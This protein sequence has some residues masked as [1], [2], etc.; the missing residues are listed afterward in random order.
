MLLGVAG[1]KGG[2]E[3]IGADV[4]KTPARRSQTSHIQTDN[5]GQQH[6]RDLQAGRLPINGDPRVAYIGKG[7]SDVLQAVGCMG[8]RIGGC[9]W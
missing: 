2:G 5:V 8:A 6:G 9:N 3:S 7:K 1:D 4:Y